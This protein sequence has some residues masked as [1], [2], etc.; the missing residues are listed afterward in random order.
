M[1]AKDVMSTKLIT[2]ASDTKVRDAVKLMLEHRISGLPVV[3]SSGKLVGLITESDLVLDAEPGLPIHLQLLEDLLGAED[4]TR[5]FKKIRDIGD[6]PVSAL[7]VKEVVTASPDTPVGEL[8]SLLV[9]SDFKRIPIVD[10]N[11]LAGLVTRADIV[12]LMG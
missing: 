8:V 1:R 5:H 7:M 11:Q 4:P 9:N 12:R 10:K 6:K 3:D 2:I